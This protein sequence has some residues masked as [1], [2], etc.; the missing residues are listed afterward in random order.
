MTESKVEEPKAI[1]R[2]RTARADAEVVLSSLHSKLLGNSLPDRMRT[3]AFALL[4]L[5]AAASLA[6]VAIFAQ[7]SF[8]LLSPAP[9][10][11]GPSQGDAVAEAVPVESGGSAPIAADR[12]AS[13]ETS[14]QDGSSAPSREGAAGGGDTGSGG[15]GAGGAPEPAGSPPATAPGGSGAGGQPGTAPAPSPSPAPAPDPDPKPA[16]PPASVP[17]ASPPGADVS[18]SSAGPGNSSSTAAAANAS[19]RGM[20]ASSKEPSPAPSASA[21]SSTVATPPS[22][23]T[24]GNG[25]AKG[26]D[27]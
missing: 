20:E 22:A 3:T 15:T 4:G 16:R 25:A 7:L 8:P 14:V 6:L 24:P 26:H 19:A 18:A 10:P 11:S 2:V 27:K 12:S 21:M 23:S 1:A 9:L 5:T 13:A 17:V